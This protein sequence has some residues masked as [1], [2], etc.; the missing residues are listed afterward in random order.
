[1]AK[2]DTVPKVTSAL[3]KIAACMHRKTNTWLTIREGVMCQCYDQSAEYWFCRM[4][5]RIGKPFCRINS[6]E[7][8]KNVNKFQNS[9]PLTRINRWIFVILQNDMLD[10]CHS[11]EWHVDFISFCRITDEILY[12]FCR[13]KHLFCRIKLFNLP[14]KMTVGDL[15][16]SAIHFWISFLF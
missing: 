3:S 2:I 4:E 8:K 16:F 11:A 14:N 1:M 7:T 5:Y 12:L 9:I 13:M 15:S 6:L 10:F